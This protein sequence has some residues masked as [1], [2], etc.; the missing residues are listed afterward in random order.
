MNIIINVSLLFCVFH[1]NRILCF[2]QLY[3]CCDLVCPR[4]VVG[5]LYYHCITMVCK[6]ILLIQLTIHKNCCFRYSLFSQTSGF[7]QKLRCFVAPW[8]YKKNQKFQLPADIGGH[9]N[10][11]SSLQAHTIVFLC[12]YQISQF[13]GNINMI[14]GDF[15]D[16]LSTSD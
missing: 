2:L 12:V 11:F 3:I 16:F 13:G 1:W 6:C 14:R 8:K 10:I 7:L 4:T 9:L 5:I 15:I